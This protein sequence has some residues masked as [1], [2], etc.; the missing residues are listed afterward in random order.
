M[1]IKLARSEIDFSSDFYKRKLMK[2]WCFYC[3]NNI[4]T[5]YY[6]VIDKHGLV[7]DNPKKLEVTSLPKICVSLRIKKKDLKIIYFCKLAK[8]LEART[9]ILVYV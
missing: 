1:E 7:R 8:L 6:G 4:D 5:I 3:L 2:W 9:N